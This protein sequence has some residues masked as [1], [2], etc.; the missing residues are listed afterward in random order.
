MKSIGYTLHGRNRWFVRLR[1]VTVSQH[2]VQPVSPHQSFYP[3]VWKGSADKSLD[4]AFAPVISIHWIQNQS[5]F[6]KRGQHPCTF[7][8]AATCYK[9][10]FPS[11]IMSD[12]ASVR[13]EEWANLWRLGCEDTTQFPKFWFSLYMINPIP[14]ELLCVK[15]NRRK[16]QDRDYNI[17]SK[18]KGKVMPVHTH[19]QRR[20]T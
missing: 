17:Y 5:S 10:W 12:R 19:H 18:S 14:G 8:H 3:W 2:P 15:Y 16:R 7:L 4:S 9:L 20:P 11:L 1:T 13:S 6:N